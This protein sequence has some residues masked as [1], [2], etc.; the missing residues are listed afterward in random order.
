MR[1]ESS[2]SQTSIRLKGTAVPGAEDRQRLIPGFDPSPLPTCVL[3]EAAR[4]TLRIS[5]TPETFVISTRGRILRHWN[6]AFVG[7]QHGIVENFF[8]VVLPELPMATQTKDQ[9][10]GSDSRGPNA[11]GDTTDIVFDGVGR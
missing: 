3:S 4:H 9:F 10:P 2:V 1:R 7:S 5:G 6:G 8:R 11:Q